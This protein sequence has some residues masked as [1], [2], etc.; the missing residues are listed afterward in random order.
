MV[1]AEAVICLDSSA[2]PS[3]PVGRVMSGK[4]LSEVEKGI[5]TD[6]NYFDSSV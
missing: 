6:A 3:T 4:S 2:T 1:G 5:N